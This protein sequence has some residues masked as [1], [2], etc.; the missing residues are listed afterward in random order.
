MPLNKVNNH[1]TVIIAGGGINGCGIA[2]DLALR[3]IDCLLVEKKD[4]SAET[5]GASS[6]LIHGGAKYLLSDIAVTRLSCLDSGYIKEIAPH[7]LFRIPFLYTVYKTPQRSSLKAKALLEAVEAYFK[8]YDAYAPLKKAQAHTR[9]TPDEVCSLESQFPKKDLVGGVTFDEWGVDVGRLC[10]ANVIDATEQGADACNHT[11]VI[12]VIR[13]DNAIKGVVL[14]D[15]ITKEK[16]QVTCDVLINATGPW[17]PQLAKKFDAHIQLR[18]T[19]GIHLVFDRKLFNMA[20]VAQAVDGR[21]I[22]IY[23]SQNV[24]IIGTTD[25][26]FF[27]DLD[28][29]RVTEDEIKYLIDAIETI[30]PAIKDARLIYA[31]SGVRPTLYERNCYEDNLSREHAIIDHEKADQVSGV[32]SLVGGKLAS[33]RIMAQE[34]CDV[35]AK[36]LNNNDPCTTHKKFLPGGE[37]V[38]D[39][40]ALALDYNIDPYACARLVYRHGSRALNILEMISKDSE[41][42]AFVCSC[43][44]VTKAEIDYVVKNEF[45]RTLSDV[46]RRT[47][48]STGPCQ[49]T[50]CLIG[51]AGLLKSLAPDTKASEHK[52]MQDFLKEWWWNRSCVLGGEQLKQEE[53]FQAVHFCNNSLDV[54]E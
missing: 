49:G 11:E 9:L 8:A 17:A 14:Q 40:N 1:Y 41:S 15:V 3:N 33:Y 44:P 4:F 6:G 53:L 54:A 39:V 29:Q 2:R 21:E 22:F 24:T 52:M 38:P 12:S 23:P 32:F 26:D 7:L 5:S 20:M 42:R 27:G 19:K 43:E 13:E 34:I 45:V 47:R 37:D 50:N 51:A 30:F 25:D 18:P 10:I 46:R 31:Y 36:K 35:V 48:F 16:K 28:D